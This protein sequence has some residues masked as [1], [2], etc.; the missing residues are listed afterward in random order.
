MKTRTFLIAAL[1][2]LAACAKDEGADGPNQ[3]GNETGDETPQ[4]TSISFTADIPAFVKGESRTTVDNNW[5]ELL[6]PTV[7]VEIDGVV[8]AYTVDVKGSLTSEDP[9]LWGDKKEVT[10]NAWYPYAQGSKISDEALTVMADQSKLENFVGSDQLEV[11]SATAT[12]SYSVLSFSHRVAKLVCS[13]TVENGT[14]EGAVVRLLNLKQV[15][16]GTSVTAT[17]DWKA[18]MVP[19]TIP[20]GQDFVEVTVPSLGNLSFVSAPVTDFVFERGKVYYLNI[21]VSEDGT[22]NVNISSSV[23]W[24]NSDTVPVPGT[25]TD[26]HPSPG[27]PGWGAGDEETGMSGESSEVTPSPGNPGWG[28]GG[29][30]TGMSGESSEVTPS[31]GN[32]GWGAGGEDTDI[33]GESSGVAPSPEAPNWG[34]GNNTDI[35]GTST[36]VTPSPV[37]PPSWGDGG[38]KNLVGEERNTS[39]GQ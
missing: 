31:P 39:S 25:S 1:Y 17:S 12:P 22:T 9:F 36:G 2:L 5:S 33:S 18:L 27:Q 6:N 3:P 20:A 37:T 16:E 10:V 24:G 28:A 14:A 38:S 32:P 30:E 34:N 13:L 26:V 4:E 23:A 35:P 8:K 15:Q 7:A 21:N 19:Q 11:I 29:E